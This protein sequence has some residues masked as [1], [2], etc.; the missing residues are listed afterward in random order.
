[1]TK[2]ALF[3]DDDL[4]FSPQF[5][6][7][8]FS[9]HDGRAECAHVFI[10]GNQLP[11][12]WNGKNRFA[13]GELGFGTGLNFLE[14]WRVWKQHRKPGQ[15][16]SFFS[17]EGFPLDAAT[18]Q[19][20]L[21]RWAELAE[22]TEQLLNQWHLIDSGVDLDDQ[23]HLQIYVGDVSEQINRFPSI[24]AWYLDGFSPAKN[25]DMW[26]LDL[27]HQLSQRTSPNGT[28][29]SYTA[30]GWVRRNLEEAGFDVEKRPGFGTKR[31]M[32]GGVKK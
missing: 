10:A 29:A 27:M 25:P 3:D 19:K 4:L 15:H 11:D 14:T 30:A 2:T 17:V 21:S 5:D 23:T 12:R 28:F 24:D 20:T 7:H 22:E 1:M 18:A 32:I 8:Y 6:D 13:I 9:R 16:L 31:D 26:S